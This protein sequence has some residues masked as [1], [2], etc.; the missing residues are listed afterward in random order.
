LALDDGDGEQ[1][2][3]RVSAWGARGGKIGVPSK[4][5]AEK[6]ENGQA[7]VIHHEGGSD[8]AFDNRA[9]LPTLRRR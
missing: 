2:A 1:H 8:E 4:L 5:N 7:T 3:C 6:P 9:A